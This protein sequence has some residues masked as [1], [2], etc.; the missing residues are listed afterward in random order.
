MHCIHPI[1]IRE[2]MSNVFWLKLSR[3]AEWAK[4]EAFLELDRVVRSLMSLMILEEGWSTCRWWFSRKDDQLE[5]ALVPLAWR[6]PPPQQQLPL[7][8]VD[9]SRCMGWTILHRSRCSGSR[10]Y[11]RNWSFTVVTPQVFIRVINPND[12]VIRDDIGQTMVHL[13][14]HL[15]N[16]TNHP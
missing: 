11:M 2:C 1:R 12:Q 9:R 6:R 3:K 14:H 8:F 5:R 15:E 16:I 13:G 10:G 7:D 4:W